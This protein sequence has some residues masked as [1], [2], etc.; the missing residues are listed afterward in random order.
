MTNIDLELLATRVYAGSGINRTPVPEGWTELVWQADVQNTGFS[1]GA[2]QN[3]NQIVTC[4][5]LG[6]PVWTRF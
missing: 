4:L 5:G 2:Y 1:A 6:I 3:G